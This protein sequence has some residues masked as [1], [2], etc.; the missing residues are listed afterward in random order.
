MPFIDQLQ[1]WAATD[2]GRPAVAAG[3]QSLSYAQLLDSAAA[4][5]E[6]TDGPGVA[7]ISPPTGT[8]LVVQFC[9]AAMHRRT[10]M[11]LDAGWPPALQ[12]RLTGLA[13][14]WDGQDRDG[15]ARNA[16]MGGKPAGSREPPFLLGLSSGTSG[17]P[18][19]FVRS[20]ASWRESFIQS[21]RYFSVGPGTITLAP[22][23]LAASMN[24]YALGESLHAGGTFVALP[25][26]TP[27]A[28]LDAMARHGVNRLV[29]VPAILELLAARGLATGRGGEK[30]HQI[31]CAG[32][33]LSRHAADLAR[34]WAPNATIQQYYGAAELGF[35][36]ASTV[37]PH[38][39]GS[40][41][42]NDGVGT[43]FPGVQLSIRDGGG[44]ALP[45]GAVGF[46]CVKSPYLGD[47]YAWGDDGLAHAVLGSDGWHT[48]HDRGS[49]NGRGVLHLAGRASDMILSAG[50]NVYPHAVEQALQPD[51]PGLA[52]MVTGIPDG[53][54]GQRI[55][56]A[57]HAGG[58]G[59]TGACIVRALRRN[60]GKLP[61]AQKPTGYYELAD[62]P[63]TGSGKASRLLLGRWIAEG[64]P[65][66]HRH[67]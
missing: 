2:P 21:S 64:D 6:N 8:G 61:A 33:S 24:L 27:G 32:S 63:L 16:R 4:A 53:L 15:L 55:V 7:V 46:V 52:V 54:R 34:M 19:A 37:H 39:S 11:V 20:A 14:D 26:F 5:P 9:A 49:V 31:V 59:G 56:A 60:A 18:K 45:A 65:R 51:I 43:A 10:A 66:A 17:V 35:V 13:R 42:A 67:R 28:A 23:P 22:G 36:A 3:G 29:L 40:G 12:H 62:L 47:G 1:H 41:P 58:T 25:R 57:F 44:H 50:T 30:V 38:G 48:V